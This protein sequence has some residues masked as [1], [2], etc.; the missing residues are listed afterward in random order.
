MLDLSPFAF[1]T[2]SV[3]SRVVEARTGKMTDANKI[4]VLR[5][6]KQEKFVLFASFSNYL[7]KQKKREKRKEV[8]ELAELL[9]LVLAVLSPHCGRTNERAHW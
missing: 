4:A 9:G 5:W 8:A 6:I 7:T 2:T 3:T 1:S